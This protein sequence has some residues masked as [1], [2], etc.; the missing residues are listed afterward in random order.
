M[1]LPPGMWPEDPTPYELINCQKC[2]LA[3]QRSRIVW[4][5]GNPNAGIF[6]L[7]DNPGAREDKSGVPF[8]CGTR[9]TLYSAAASVCLGKNDLYVTYVVRCRP[10]KKYDKEQARSTCINHL[11]DQLNTKIPKLVVCLGNVAAQ[12]YLANS[13]T[14]VKDLR[15]SI[16]FYNGIAAAFSYHPLA[17][18]RRPI[19][20]RLFLE[21]WNLIASYY[22]NEILPSIGAS[23]S[24]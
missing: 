3:L 17:V 23:F 14:E 18:R 10:V 5:E 16:S 7:L 1:P 15:G 13:E 8:I 19:L 11:Q 12:S 6:I 4:G 24:H 2:S 22:R 21:D 9:Q 20:N